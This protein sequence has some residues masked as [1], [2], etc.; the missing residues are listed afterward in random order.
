M[1][2]LR[3]SYGERSRIRSR[4]RRRLLALTPAEKWTGPLSQ[5]LDFARDKGEV[6]IAKELKDEIFNLFALHN[7]L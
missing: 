6:G 4:K 7:L 1:S 5:S 3:H 2:K